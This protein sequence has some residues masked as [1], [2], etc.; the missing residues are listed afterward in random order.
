[1]QTILGILLATSSAAVVIATI[2]G[3]RLAQDI[4]RKK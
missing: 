1:M 2:Q 4:I 3:C